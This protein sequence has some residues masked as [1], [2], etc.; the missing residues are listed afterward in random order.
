MKAD[1]LKLAENTEALDKL[2]AEAK[3]ELYKQVKGSEV[4]NNTY[5][6]YM[7]SYWLGWVSSETSTGLLESFANEFGKAK[8]DYM[9]LV[10]EPTYKIQMAKPVTPHKV[11]IELDDILN[12]EED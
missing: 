9:C 2:I 10:A 5:H 8:I 3:F 7:S 4:E 1:I 12:C 6:L 11:E